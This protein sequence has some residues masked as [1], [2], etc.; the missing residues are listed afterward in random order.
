MV[1]EMRILRERR[2]AIDM[3]GTIN[4]PRF[5]ADMYQYNDWMSNPRS[6]LWV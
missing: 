6:K 1:M 5:L 3:H 4:C 2:E